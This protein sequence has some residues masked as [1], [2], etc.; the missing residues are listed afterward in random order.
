MSTKALPSVEPVAAPNHHDFLSL[1]TQRR[2][3]YTLSPASTIPDTEIQRILEAILTQAPSTFG[4]YTTRMIL[5]VKEE[6]YK[7][8]DT[9]IATVKSVT[10]EAKWAEHTKPRLDG[11]RNAY[12]TVMF[13]EDPTNTRVM[14]E[15]FPFAK[16]QFPIF[17]RETN[18]MH[19]FAVWSAFTAAGL[20]VNL[21]HYNPLIDGKV[22]AQYNVPEDWTLTSQLVFGTPTQ[23]SHPK[24]TAMAAPMTERL[25]VLGADDPEEMKELEVKWEENA[26]L[27]RMTSRMV[28]V[29]A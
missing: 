21:Q 24:P 23:P 5:V 26:T 12:G 14:Q 9:I 7:L 3:N 19:Q 6:H 15:K 29:D 13:F 27:V 18:A 17:G 25:R 11:F 2:T 8:W 28:K 22:Q 4:S 10:P 16:D 20:G 1:M